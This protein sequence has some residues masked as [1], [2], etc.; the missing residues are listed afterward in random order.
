MYFAQRQKGTRV[1]KEFMLNHKFQVPLCAIVSLWIKK[2]FMKNH[3][4]LNP[5]GLLR[6]VLSRCRCVQMAGILSIILFINSCVV[7]YYPETTENEELLIVEGMITNQHEVYTIKLHKSVPLWKVSN[8]KPLKGCRVWI[9]DDQEKIDSLK[10]ISIGTYVSDPATFQGEIGKKYILHI[11]T[12][13]ANGGLHYES[14][15]VEMKPVPPIDRIYYEKKIY[16]SYPRPVEGCQIY[17]DTHDPLNKSDFYKWKYSE[18]WE[19]HLPYD[20]ENKICWITNNSNE[21]F[22]KN[23]SLLEDGKVIGFPL[24]SIPDPIDKLSVKYSILVNQYSMNEEEYLYWERLKNTMNEMGG[25][26]DMIP[27]V[28]PNNVY[29]LEKPEEKTL[30]YFSVSAVSSKRAFIKDSFSA[31][32]FKYVDCISDTIYGTGP[33][34]PGIWVIVD[35]SNLTPPVR[36]ITRN[37][38]CADCRTRGTNIKPSFWDDDIK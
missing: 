25:L 26:Y 35:H 13:A 17:L 20:V 34:A 16:S 21:L 7:P 9:S 38:A 14:S 11:N 37:M 8:E 18:T 27:A 23:A 15:P 36:Y 32:N 22:I 24:N 33:I 10:E 3:S 6:N 28:I 19:F 2:T 5:I 4:F 30:G 29:C 1:P 12:T 31:Y